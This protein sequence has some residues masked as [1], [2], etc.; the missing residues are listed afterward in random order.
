MSRSGRIQQWEPDLIPETRTR[1]ARSAALRIYLPIGVA[2]LV[3]LGL[4]VGIA[5][6]GGGGRMQAWSQLAVVLMAAMLIGAGFAALV[7]LTA[8]AVGIGKLVDILP[9]FSVRMRKY[10]ALAARE[11]LRASDLVTKPVFLVAETRAMGAGILEFLDEAF[12]R[13]IRKKGAGDGKSSG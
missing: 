9:R 4:V 5:A 12:S 11:T 2:A 10:T 8:A 7:I 1:L 13:L 6:G 3:A